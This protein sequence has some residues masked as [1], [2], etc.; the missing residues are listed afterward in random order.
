M[1]SRVFAL[2]LVAWLPFVSWMVPMSPVFATATLFFGV[3]AL[4]LAGVSLVYDRARFALGAVGAL[5]AFVPF[6]FQATMLETV[7]SVSWGAT[8]LVCMV[9]PFS[10]AP[11]VTRTA[12]GAA[13]ARTPMIG[14]APRTAIAAPTTDADTL[15]QAA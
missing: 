13:A 4:G 1:L 7:V 6:V 5:V 10:A 2:S 15:T 11:E 8:L 3:I 14:A 12:A 9:G